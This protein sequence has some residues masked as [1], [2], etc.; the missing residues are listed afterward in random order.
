M[1]MKFEVSG[2][3]LLRFIFI[4]ICASIII[5][6]SANKI[7][8]VFGFINIKNI[9][10]LISMQIKDLSKDGIPVWSSFVC[11]P[12]I[13]KLEVESLKRGESNGES[14]DKA[15]ILSPEHITK[16]STNALTSGDWTE[17]QEVWPC[18]VFNPRNIRFFPGEVDQIILIAYNDKEI[19][20]SNPNGILFGI[21]D[22]ER[23]MSSVQP[24]AG[25]IPSVNTFTFTSSVR[26]NLYDGFHSSFFVNMQ[27]IV[28]QDEPFAEKKILTRFL[29]S[30]DTY[31]TNTY[32]ERRPY[33]LYDL[34][35]SV[36]GLMTLT[37]VIWFFL[38]GRGKYRSWGIVQRYL[39]HTSPNAMR[40]DDSDQLLPISYKDKDVERQMSSNT[41]LGSPSTITGK[42]VSSSPPPISDNTHTNSLYYFSATGTPAQH[43]F[44]PPPFHPISRSKSLNKKIDARINQKLWFV[45]QTLSRHYL[46]GFRL[47]VRS[48]DQNSLKKGH[49]SSSI[50][51]FNP[52]EF[53]PQYPNVTVRQSSLEEKPMRRNKINTES[54]DIG[55]GYVSAST[56]SSSH[57]PNIPVQLLPRKTIT[58]I[59]K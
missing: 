37:S 1:L 47:H 57:L 29:Y 58:I 2:E 56:P 26:H 25:P 54:T 9:E 7:N 31:L 38:F 44:S 27:N 18:F 12:N 22:E 48:L 10:P 5:G 30:P 55:D 24:F 23:N 8:I 50:S 15:T 45:E 42:P 49:T 19:I 20:K 3:H 21:F 28:R 32:T 40:K 13:T 39:L 16:T 52:E 51:S 43:E 14:K 6:V 36:G 17:K 35:S 46:S 41:L 11:S 53:R 4:V 33:T 59:T 34:V